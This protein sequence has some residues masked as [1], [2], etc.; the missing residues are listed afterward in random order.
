[1]SYHSAHLTIVL[2]HMLK[3]PSVMSLCS[4]FVVEHLGHPDIKG[5]TEQKIVFLLISRHYFTYSKVPDPQV[6]QADL[7]GWIERFKKPALLPGCLALLKEMEGVEETS[8]QVAMGVINHIARKCLIEP[9]MEK[10]IQEATASKSL[11]GLSSRLTELRQQESDFQY[12]SKEDD[13]FE[14]KTD[15]TYRVSTQIPWLDAQFGGGKGLPAGMAIGIIAP[16]NAGKTT[17]G[18]MLAVNQALSGKVAHLALFEEGLSLSLQA[19]ILSCATGIEWPQ[20]AEEINAVKSADTA[21][22]NLAKKHGLSPELVERKLALLRENLKVSDCVNYD[23][24]VMRDLNFVFEYNKRLLQKKRELTYT[25]I[26]WAGLLA[27]KMI[28]L[29][30]YAKLSKEQMLQHISQMVSLHASETNTIVAI[31]QQ[32]SVMD[33]KRGPTALHNAY[34][35]A[36][37]KM[38]TAPFK[39][40]VSINERDKKTGKSL[41]QTIKS[42]DDAFGAPLVLDFDGARVTFKDAS[43]TWEVDRRKFVRKAKKSANA[44]PQRS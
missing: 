30:E 35:A 12:T 13:V 4:R 37:C 5:T 1:M 14:V 27:D 31:S 11:S 25:Y 22:L 3:N 34:C 40:A 20:I 24:G 21:L 39:Y 29:K 23:T 28:L 2:G 10:A 9:G 43:D 41:F 44:V 16:Q 8:L 17:L 42:R 38:F 36:D 26:D 19:K 18:I 33:V 6:L 15:L 32:M 7:Q